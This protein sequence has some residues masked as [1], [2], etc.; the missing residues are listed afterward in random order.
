MSETEASGD[1]GRRGRF[2]TFEGGEGAGKS[3]QLTRLADRLRRLGL[4]VITTREPGGS[5]GAEALRH[6]LLSGAAE[7][8]GPEAEAILFAAARADH[9][10]ALIRPAVASGQWVICDRFIDSTRVYQGITGNVPPRLIAALESIS[11]GTMLPDLTLLLDL[12]AAE[13]LKRAAARRGFD[14]ADRFE[15]DGI[16]LHESRRDGFLALARSE[17]DRFAVIDAAQEVETVAEAVWYAVR[18]RLGI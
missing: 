15:K 18:R 7:A 14:T 5:P 9:V 12:P 3:T 1:G 6:V 13:G 8:L 10:E 11:V 16:D 2:V 4:S 17:P